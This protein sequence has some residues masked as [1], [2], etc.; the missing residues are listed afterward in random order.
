MKKYVIWRKVTL[1][2]DIWE[3]NI[4][5]SD[6][7]NWIW[8]HSSSLTCYWLIPRLQSHLSSSGNDKEVLLWTVTV[9]SITFHVSEGSS[10]GWYTSSP[11]L[12]NIPGLP[13]SY[14]VYYIVRSSTV[15]LYGCLSFALY[16]IDNRKFNFFRISCVV[17]AIVSN[18]VSIKLHLKDYRYLY[19]L[20][21]SS[22]DT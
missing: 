4:S 7:S 5:L 20:I 2:W 21:V 1:F 22:I 10:I 14:F 6:W 3:V 11:L 15:L 18:I 13:D 9:S 19:C 8:S 16:T 17:S 12:P